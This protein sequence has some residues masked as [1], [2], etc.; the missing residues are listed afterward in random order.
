MQFTDPL[1]L[2]AIFVALA[3]GGILKGATGAGAPVLAIPV[4]AAFFDVRMA[5]VMMIVPNLL[6]NLLQVWKFRDQR[7]GGSLPWLFAVGGAAGALLG[8]YLLANLSVDTLSL[9]VAGGVLLY[10]AVRLVWPGMVL[11]LGLATRLAVPMG[12]AA[13]VLQGA[14]GLS[15]PVSITF[16]NA[17]RL[18][19]VLFIS[20][21][22]LFFAVM[23]LAQMPA[24][25]WVGILTPTT[26]LFSCL[27]LVPLLG[28]MPVG[29]W[30]ARSVSKD[31]F[32]RVLLALLAVLAVKLI[33]SALS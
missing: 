29:G 15:A 33:L 30:L 10:I 4:I 2:V 23:S 25:V 5:V 20:T 18:E 24:L 6:T 26:L 17:I 32:D 3:L 8:T 7:L 13:G 14:S 16:L 9:I 1:A 27:A 21:I 11:S 28:F 12:V 19:R 31:A 22:S